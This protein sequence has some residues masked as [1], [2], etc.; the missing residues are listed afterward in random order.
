MEPLKLPLEDGPEVLN[1]V[2]VGGV[3]RPL[4]DLNPV[5]PDPL[6]GGL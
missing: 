1:S 2:E 4:D 6:H 3:P 5:V